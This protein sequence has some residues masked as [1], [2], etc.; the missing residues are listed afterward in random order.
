MGP[1]WFKEIWFPLFE[2]IFLKSISSL[3]LM[4][5]KSSLEQF[6]EDTWFGDLTT[7]S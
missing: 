5:V 7:A 3:L 1:S 4:L 6:L 2:R